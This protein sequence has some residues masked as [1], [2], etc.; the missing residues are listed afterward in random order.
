MS[1]ILKSSFYRMSKE[2]S[3]E[4][5]RRSF[6]IGLTS[7]TALIGATYI[8]SL[9]KQIK[10][11]DAGVYFQIDLANLC[12][13]ISTVMYSLFRYYYGNLQEITPAVIVSGFPMPAIQEVSHA[14]SDRIL[15][16]RATGGIFLA[17]QEGGDNTLRIIGK[18]Y[19]PNRYL[20]LTILDFLFLYGSTK[21]VDYLTYN[22]ET[23]GTELYPEKSEW[24]LL[25]VYSLDELKREKHYTFPVITKNKIYMNMYIETYEF[26]DSVENG[27]DCLTYTIFFRKYVVQDVYKY[28]HTKTPDGELVYWYTETE[29]KITKDFGMIDT[30]LDFGLSSAMIIYSLMEQIH[31]NSPETALAIKTVKNLADQYMG[32]DNAGE[33]LYEATNKTKYNLSSLTVKQKE[34]LVQ[35]D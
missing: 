28:S 19:G 22:I 14:V 12:N 7:A 33:I 13:N 9:V 17:H 16:Y 24:Q 4:I 11:K 8:N 15:K 21:I 35:I 18:A 31:G 34:E 27:L 2:V 1:M 5:G 29:D 26:V 30:I 3:N 20:F 32:V 6:A 23:M 25:D 10:L